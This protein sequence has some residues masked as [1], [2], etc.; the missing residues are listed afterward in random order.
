MFTYILDKNIKKVHSKHTF[1]NTHINRT[2]IK[3]KQMVAKY[4]Y[5]IPVKYN[6]HFVHFLIWF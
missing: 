5:F 4:Q 1:S 2:A 6:R 3:R